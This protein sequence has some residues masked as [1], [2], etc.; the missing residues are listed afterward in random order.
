MRCVSCRAWSVDI[1]CHSC[2]ESY[3]EPKVSRRMI[4][5]LEVV[6]LYSY[7]T[8]EPLLVTKKSP[9]GYRIYRFLGKR[10]MRPFIEAFVAHYSSKVYIVGVDEVVKGGYAHVALLTHAMK[11]KRSLPLH[12]TLLARSGVKY[13]GNSLAFRQQHPRDFLYRGARDIEVILVDDVITTGTTLLEAYHLLQKHGVEVL[14]AVT[15]ADASQ[16]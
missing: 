9:L 5:S 1:V 6:S 15:L 10:V 4:G 14:F 8:L 16:R 7:S 3:F 13:A 11:T 2:W 12:G